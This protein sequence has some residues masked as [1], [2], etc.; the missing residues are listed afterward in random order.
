MCKCEKFCKIKN[1]YNVDILLEALSEETLSAIAG[2]LF[3][4]TKEDYLIVKGAFGQTEQL[5]EFAKTIVEFLFHNRLRKLTGI[6]FDGD[7]VE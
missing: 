2:D 1:G 3:N 7:P 4:S 6:D 5:D